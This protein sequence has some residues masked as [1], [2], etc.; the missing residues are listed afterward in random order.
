MQKIKFHRWNLEF[1]AFFMNKY[2]LSFEFFAILARKI[3]RTY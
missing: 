2:G 1:I 3:L